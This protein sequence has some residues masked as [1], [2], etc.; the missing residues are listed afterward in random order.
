MSTKDRA[1]REQYSASAAGMIDKA[2][3]RGN[4]GTYLKITK[5]LKLFQPKEDKV[6]RLRFLTFK[7]GKN[8][9]AYKEGERAVNRFIFTHGMVGPEQISV[10]CS[11]KSF[12]NPVLCVKALPN[13]EH[14]V[15]N[16]RRSNTCN[17]RPATCS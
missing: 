4:K 7:A 10:T 2:P 5:N 12:G 14:A 16:G 1:R 11:Q 17:T 13:C 3:M 9:P 8:N 6:Y 15:Q